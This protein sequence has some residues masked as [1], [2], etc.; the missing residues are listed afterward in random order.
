MYFSSC[1][2]QGCDKLLSNQGHCWLHSQW[3]QWAK[4]K[5][6]RWCFTCHTNSPISP[7]GSLSRDQQRDKLSDS[8]DD[9]EPGIF[10]SNTEAMKLDVSKTTVWLKKNGVEK[11][12]EFLLMSRPPD[13]ILRG[14]DAV[15]SEKEEKTV[16][17]RTSYTSPCSTP[18]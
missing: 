15:F 10:C 3:W 13:H 6:G 18:L 7:S 12:E 5:M 14:H 9:T 16:W 4:N 2:S 17:T 8:G 11:E 1:Y